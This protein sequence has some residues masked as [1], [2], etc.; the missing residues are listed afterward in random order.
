VKLR[1]NPNAVSTKL[2]SYPS[3]HSTSVPITQT[4]ATANYSFENR[5][6]RDSDEHAQALQDWDQTYSQLTSGSFKGRLVEARFKGLQIFRETTNLSVSQEGNSREDCLVMGI[7]VQMSGTGLFA[8]QVLTQDSLLCF[9]GN[10]GFSLKSPE[11][12][13]IVVVAIPEATLLEATGLVTHAELVDT[14]PKSPTVQLA[15]SPLI[16]NLRKSLLSILK[17]DQFEPAMLCY[18]QVQQEITSEIIDHL[19]NVLQAS[20]D[21]PLPTRSFKSRSHVVKQAT[22]YALDRASEQVT[23]VDLCHHLKISRRMLNYC[24]M[25]VLDTNPV[26]Y[27]RTLRLNYVR[28]ELRQP[29]P[30]HAQ[31]RDIA[32]KWG[33]WHLP[34]FAAEYRALF[35]ELPS[36][37]ARNGRC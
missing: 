28:R 30:A 34:R 33:F 18:P 19:V 35:G 2:D 29:M 21:A 3:C 27:L 31:I 26:N 14:L 23:I 13:D 9:P 32:G 1:K 20:S 8:R 12:F 17:H 5:T 6:S 37:T 4:A 22:D 24:F 36:A 16:N 25:E 10:R 15:P 11:H 7:P